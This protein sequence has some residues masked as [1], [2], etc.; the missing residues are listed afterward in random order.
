MDKHEMILENIVNSSVFPLRSEKMHA[1]Y[2]T[3]KNN[4]NSLLSH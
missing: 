4:I 2:R 3:L 1:Y